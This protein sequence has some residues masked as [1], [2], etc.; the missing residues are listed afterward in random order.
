MPRSRALPAAPDWLSS[1]Q[2]S[3]TASDLYASASPRTAAHWRT[4]ARGLAALGEGHG[5]S[6]G[7]VQEQIARQIRDMGLTFR[8][9]GDEAERDWPLTPMPLIIG[10][11]EWGAIEAGVVQ[12]ADLLEG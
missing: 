4:M 9:A 2:P 1:Y 12:R 6:G 8:I 7:G 11:E 5:S 3:D 10:G